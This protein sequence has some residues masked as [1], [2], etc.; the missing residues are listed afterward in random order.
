MIKAWP[1]ILWAF[2]DEDFHLENLFF[3]PLD[4]QSV[5]LRSQKQGLG[6]E[7]SEECLASL[8]DYCNQLVIAMGSKVTIRPTAFKEGDH[9]Y[10]PAIC[11]I[12][13]QILAVEKMISDEKGGANK[14]Y[15][16]LREISGYS[17]DDHSNPFEFE[18]FEKLWK[19]FA[20]ELKTLKKA[21]P[22]NITFR[23]GEPGQ[24]K[25]RNYPMSQSL[26]DE[27]SLRVIHNAIKRID[28][29]TDNNLVLLASVLPNITNRSKRNLKKR[30]LRSAIAT[31]IRAFEPRASVA[32]KGRSPKVDFPIDTG[33]ASVECFF[34]YRDDEDFGDDVW[35]IEYHDP[36]S[37]M[38]SAIDAFN[39]FVEKEEFKGVFFHA[40]GYR[41]KPI[42]LASAI[43]ESREASF[44][45]IRNENYSELIERL[46]ELSSNLI[47]E[48]VARVPDGLM[49]LQCG[50]GIIDALATPKRGFE[51][52]L[53]FSGGIS[54]NAVSNI[55]LAGYP[56]ERISFNGDAL[57]PE[58][59]INVDGQQTTVK[60][61]LAACLGVHDDFFEVAYQ[62]HRKGLR[63]LANRDVVEDP[64]VVGFW[65]ENGKL[66]FSSKQEAENRLGL[67]HS[68]FLSAKKRDVG[69]VI[70]DW[71]ANGKFETEVLVDF[72]FW[73]P[74]SHILID[75]TLAEA[76]LISRT[77]PQ[78]V[79]RLREG[80]LGK[81]RVPPGLYKAFLDLDDSRPLL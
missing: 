28:K 42:S 65:I 69:C 7:S 13:L 20:K 41:Q 63:M 79:A 1:D 45:L 71:I 57:S 26:L 40:D 66:Q 55:Y 77:K 58:M 27:Q 14:Y 36:G 73:L 23:R 19:Q 60:N 39:Y 35:C 4:Q 70:R 64:P 76:R 33:A 56:P 62:G 46:G 9:G 67:S 31:Q 74:V 51:S 68:V 21:Q 30:V 81:Q 34:L 29:K 59:R 72:K 50:S 11:M 80:V 32:L 38:L 37:P 44:L 3:L 49:L 8:R 24:N 43:K 10:S 5:F 47:S 22:H 6:W 75:G 2:V 61:F 15:L 25:Y 54:V 18:D 78:L 48:E 17:T 12:A 52:P 53:S 16:R